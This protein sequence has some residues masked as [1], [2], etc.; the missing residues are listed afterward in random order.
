M[1]KIY[2]NES[3]I[4]LIGNLGQLGSEIEKILLLQNYKYIAINRNQ[5]DLSN[6]DTLQNFLNKYAFSL[7]INCA[8]FTNVD[9]AEKEND[10][11]YK[12]NSELPKLLALYCKRNKTMLIHFSTDFI[13]NGLKKTPYTE[14]DQ[15]NPLNTYGHSKLIGEQ[16]IINLFNNYLILR[17]S[18]VFGNSHN[19]FIYK[20]IKKLQTEK[21]FKIVDD[22]IS[23]P[24]PSNFISFIINNIIKKINL[25]KK[26]TGIYHAVPRGYISKYDL[27]IQ[28]K[29]LMKIKKKKLVNQKLIAIKSS[30]LNFIAHRPLYSVLSSNLLENQLQIKFEDWSFYGNV[31]I[32]EILDANF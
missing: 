8:A 24:T 4:L 15:T 12:I 18:S 17:V 32:M 14:Y 16:N 3:K 11:A 9:L 6:F 1:S 29:K 7:I 22:Q 19:N 31:K 2:K 21:E 20:V 5:I 30:E 28:V 10:L 25:K 26:F 23:S 13:F 27:A